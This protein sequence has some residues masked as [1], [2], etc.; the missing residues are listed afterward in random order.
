MNNKIKNINKAKTIVSQLA[1]KE[2][3]IE[4]LNNNRIAEVETIIDIQES[5]HF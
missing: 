2:S 4:F 5:S 1:N 3:A